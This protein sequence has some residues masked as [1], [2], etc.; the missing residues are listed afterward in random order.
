VS[1]HET[2]ARIS[3]AIHTADPS[4]EAYLFGSR[5]RGDN[6]EDSDWD[7]IILVDDER[8]N[9][10]VDNKFLDALYDIELEIEQVI[11]A[12]VYTKKHWYG[13]MSFS[14]LFRN[15]NKEGIKL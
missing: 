6:R 7:I 2:L 13:P 12:F 9:R 4:A 11:T 3:N 14:P 10:D 5:A 1:P 15:V 8:V